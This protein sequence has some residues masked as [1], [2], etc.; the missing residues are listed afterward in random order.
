MHPLIS[1][2][3]LNMETENYLDLIAKY[4]SGNITTEER[5]ILL[6]WVGESEENRQYFDEMIQL[7]SVP[8][9]IDETFEAN[10]EPAWD[11]LENALF[12]HTPQEIISDTPKIIPFYKKTWILRIAAAVLLL[13]TG[14]YF[15]SQQ[16]IT[17]EIAVTAENLSNDFLELPDGSKVWLNKDS[18]L[19]FDKPFNV[20]TV[21]LSGEAF[22]E[23][24]RDTKRPFTI[25]T[26]NAKT[27]VLGTSFNLRAYPE[28]EEVELVVKTGKVKFESLVEEDSI[29]LEKEESAAFIKETSEVQKKNLTSKNILAWKLGTIRF[30]DTPIKEVVADLQRYFRKEFKVSNPSL[31]NCEIRA[32]YTD[33]M[34]LDAFLEVLQATFD[35]SIKKDGDTYILD[36]IC[37][38]PK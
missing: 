8:V 9:D 35:F 15:V 5:N 11:K 36:G 16:F 3:H 13:L 18:E 32:T 34:E 6:S 29:L 20:R 2:S 21:V 14:G 23:I 12:D 27:T 30:V 24:E 38:N 4:L 28:E 7:W 1:K 22:F 31:A 37:S 19:K 17:K 25:I 10:I 33:E 26:G